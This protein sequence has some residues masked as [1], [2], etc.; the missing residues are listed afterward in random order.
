MGDQLSELAGIPKYTRKL[1][2]NTNAIR[3]AAELNYTCIY[4]S[5]NINSRQREALRVMARA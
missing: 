5:G 1:L 2:K 3:A 4:T